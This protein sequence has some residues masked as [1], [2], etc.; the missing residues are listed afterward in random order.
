M[1]RYH[2]DITDSH[3]HSW[4]TGEFH[5]RIIRFWA[6]TTKLDSEF[7]E[8]AAIRFRDSSPTTDSL[9]KVGS[10]KVPIKDGRLAAISK[11]NWEAL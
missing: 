2:G 4:V 3:Q 5:K 7:V 9:E 1:L 6:Y 8:W 11:L 10:L